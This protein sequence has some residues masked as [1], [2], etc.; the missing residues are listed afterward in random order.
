MTGDELPAAARRRRTRARRI[1]YGLVAYGVIGIGLALA[2]LIALAGP[3]SALD[4]LASRRADA[5]RWLDAAASGLAAAERSGDGAVAALTAAE[6]SARSA[7]GLFGELSMAMAGLREA[8]SITIL[9]TRPLGGLTDDLDRVAQRSATLADEMAVLAGSMAAERVSLDQLA[10]EAGRLQI[11]MAGLRSLVA[12]GEPGASPSGLSLAGLAGLMAAWLVL[13]AVAS[14][15]VGI[16]R[17][18]RLARPRRDSRPPTPA[19][20][21]RRPI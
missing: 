1:A 21:W 3:I 14:L 16:D 7:A 4:S 8:S 19:A 5:V 15:V 6:T 12:S 10:R 9:G 2:S 11:E 20:A 17:L 13:P 18:R